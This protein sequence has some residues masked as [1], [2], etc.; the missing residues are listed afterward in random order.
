MVLGRTN[1]DRSQLKIVDNHI[2]ENARRMS[3]AH[4]KT[5]PTATANTIDVPAAT[6]ALLAFP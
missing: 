5:H 2:N 4:L 1:T 6:P 3:V